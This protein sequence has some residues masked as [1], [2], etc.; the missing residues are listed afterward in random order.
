MK[1]IVKGD[2]VD[3]KATNLFGIVVDVIFRNTQN[4]DW[5][6]I[7]VMCNDGS[8]REFRPRKL[9]KKN[10]DFDGISVKDGAE[11]DKLIMN[12]RSGDTYVKK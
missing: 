1:R 10:K 12:K 11:L 6:L 9:I 5:D 3:V 8:L 4:P 2:L 7:S